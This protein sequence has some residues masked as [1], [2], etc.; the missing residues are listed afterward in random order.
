MDKHFE[1][2]RMDLLSHLAT[3]EPARRHDVELICKRSESQLHSTA[4]DPRL[5]RCENDRSRRTP[6]AWLVRWDSCRHEW[7]E[8]RFIDETL[9]GR[10]IRCVSVPSQLFSC[11]RRCLF[12]CRFVHPRPRIPIDS[13][14]PDEHHHTRFDLPPERQHLHDAL[15]AHVMVYLRVRVVDG[16]LELFRRRTRCDI[17]VI[18]VHGRPDRRILRDPI[19]M[20]GACP[21][22]S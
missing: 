22:R 21:I 2:Q 19:D 20:G 12:R 9:R 8:T 5:R 13:L 16:F 10:V 18:E 1:F 3:L 15:V 17:L 7:R 11:P 4:R 6:A 14:R